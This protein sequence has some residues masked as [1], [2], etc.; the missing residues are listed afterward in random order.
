M[1]KYIDIGNIVTYWFAV[2]S[3]IYNNNSLFLHTY[4]PKIY[5]FVYITNCKYLGII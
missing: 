4:S 2:T 5:K 3:T 1:Y